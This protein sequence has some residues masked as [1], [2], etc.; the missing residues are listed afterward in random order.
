LQDGD[1]VEFDPVKG[2][3]F[4]GTREFQLPPMPDFANSIVKAG[5]IVAYVR[6]NGQFPGEK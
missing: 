2:I 4:S 3:L 5:G 1:S 6:E